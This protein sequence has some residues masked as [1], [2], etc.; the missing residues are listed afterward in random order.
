MLFSVELQSFI[1]TYLITAGIAGVA[2]VYQ[3]YANLVYGRAVHG[4][5]YAT[6]EEHQSLY[7][8]ATRSDRLYRASNWLMCGLFAIFMAGC[9]LAENGSGAPVI[10]L[11]A[12]NFVAGIVC[13]I[14]WV[15]HRLKQDFRRIAGK[16]VGEAFRDTGSYGVVA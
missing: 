3:Y 4:V 6:D 1:V 9:I 5:Q 8:I 10:M 11:A 7:M 12:G 16:S 14:A 15:H 2:M 13:M